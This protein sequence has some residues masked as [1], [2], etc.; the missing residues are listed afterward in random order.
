VNWGNLDYFKSQNWYAP[1]VTSKPNS[2]VFVRT[3]TEEIT[4]SC[5]IIIDG[6]GTALYSGFQASVIKAGDRIICSSAISSMGTG[7]AETIGASKFSKFSRYVCI[8]GDGS[9]LMNVQDLQTIRQDNINVIVCVINNNGYLAIRNTQKE[10]L[11]GRYFGCHPDWKL[12]MPSFEKIAKAFDIDYLRLD[13][14]ENLSHTVQKLV[15]TRGPILCEV[16]VEEDQEV[17][18]K[19]GYKANGNGTFSPLALSEMAPFL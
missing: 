1:I 2:N 5:C 11:D 9:L 16:V 7:L 12:T 13:R 19:Q 14:T 4:E 18:F 15:S 8:I 17:L 10:F 3:L 6:G